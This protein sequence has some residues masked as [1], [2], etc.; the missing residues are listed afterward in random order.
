MTACLRWAREPSLSLF[1][2]I[3]SNRVVAPNRPCTSSVAPFILCK[4]VRQELLYIRATLVSFPFSSVYSASSVKYC[5]NA[6][7]PLALY[8]LTYSAAW[9]VIAV[10][11]GAVVFSRGIRGNGGGNQNNADAGDGN[12]SNFHSSL[13]GCQDRLVVGRGQG[14][15]Y[16]LGVDL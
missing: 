13:F 16:N 14:P 5:A 7:A 8:A 3:D 11:S 9:F 10:T 15:R 2:H 1:L 12:R 4:R 6:F